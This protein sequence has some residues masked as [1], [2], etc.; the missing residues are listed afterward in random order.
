MAGKIVELRAALQAALLAFGSRRSTPGAPLSLSLSTSADDEAHALH[1]GDASSTSPST[2]LRPKLL[3][4]SAAP[5][6][7]AVQA[8]AVAVAGGSVRH[9]RHSTDRSLREVAWRAA[10]TRLR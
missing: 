9:R 1:H 4:S 2:S 6:F 5:W 10:T 7:V 3:L 8:F